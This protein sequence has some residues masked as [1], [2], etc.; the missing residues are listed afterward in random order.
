MTRTRLFLHAAVAAIVAFGI[1]GQQELN[2]Q[3]AAVSTGHGVFVGPSLP[4]ADVATAPA[5]YQGIVLVGIDPPATHPHAWPC[6]PGDSGC[7]SL[8]PNGFVIPYPY[9]VIPINAA[10]MIV[11]TFTTNSASGTADVNVTVTQGKTT[12]STGSTNF[13]VSA[14]GQYYAYFPDAA[15]SGA[16]KGA[17]T[18]TVTTTVG[19]ATITGKIT[20]HVQ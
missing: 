5:M 3:D 8:P 13:A 12:I 11:S 7:P 16:T 1:C 9:Q 15:L 17:E 4:E 6:V 2:A 20:I 10:G 19:S 14:N 18:V